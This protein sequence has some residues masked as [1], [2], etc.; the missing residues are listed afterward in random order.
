MHC[1]SAAK[2]IVTLIRDSF[3]WLADPGIVRLGFCVSYI[4]AGFRVFELQVATGFVYL[5]AVFGSVDYERPGIMAHF[6]FRIKTD[7]VQK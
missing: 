3:I 2:I 1:H 7:S 6:I 5:P 4:F